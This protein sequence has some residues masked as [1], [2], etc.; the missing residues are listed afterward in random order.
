MC[1][2]II[3][4]S[5]Y[6]GLCERKIQGKLRLR[7][8]ATVY[9]PLPYRFLSLAKAIKKGKK[10]ALNPISSFWHIGGR[11]NTAHQRDNAIVIKKKR[12]SFFQIVY[13]Y[14]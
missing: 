13:K 6:S 7:E 10:D 9:L 5:V 4:L 8:I 12:D 2:F 14:V 3:N 11:K 1:F